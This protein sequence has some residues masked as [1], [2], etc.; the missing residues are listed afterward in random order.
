MSRFNQKITIQVQHLPEFQ[1]YRIKNKIRHG[2]KY[3]NV[4]MM[5]GDV[6]SGFYN[7]ILELLAKLIVKKAQLG[8]LN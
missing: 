1:V 4:T 6:Y 8:M 3:S 2:K 5:N 7:D